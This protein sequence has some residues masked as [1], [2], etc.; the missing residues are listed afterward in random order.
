MPLPVAPSNPRPGKDSAGVI[1]VVDDQPEN[2]QLMADVLA[3][4]G[5]AT[6][7]ANGGAEALRLLEGQRPN[8]I[9][10]DMLMPEMDGFELIRRIR[11]NPA[12]ADIPIMVITAMLVG[13]DERKR[14]E[15]EAQSIF[16]KGTF[17]I[18]DLLKEVA[19]IIAR[20]PGP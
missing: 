8:A 13:G 7:G 17:W 3:T 1:L 18:E 12:T 6:L 5:Y 14:L 15:R 16:Q 11:G 20:K 2:V 19:R 9:L 4:A 10:L